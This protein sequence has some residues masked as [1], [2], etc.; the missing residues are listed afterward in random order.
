MP[1]QL[2]FIKHEHIIQALEIYDEKEMPKDNEWSQ[3]W[4]HY[5]GTLYQYKYVVAQASGFAGNPMKTT[6]FK[7]ND[8]SRNYIS[9]LGFHIL[10]REPKLSSGNPNFWIAGHH[11]GEPGNQQDMLHDFLKR[12]YWGTDHRPEL[13]EGKW[14]YNQLQHIRINDRIAIR[15]YDRKGGRVYILA[16]GTIAG[17]ENIKEGELSV[18]WDYHPPKYEGLKPTGAGTGNWWKTIFELKRPQDINLIFGH[19]FPNEFLEHRVCRLVWNDNGWIMPS[20]RDGKSNYAKSHEGAYG[21]GN[22]EWIFD[23]GKLING[24]HYALLAPIYLQEKTYSGKSF[25][26]SLYSIDGN[27]KNYYWVAE[28]K[29]TIVIDQQEAESVWKYYKEKGWLTKME[30]QI[31][32]KKG[33]HKS[34]RRWSGLE[35]FNIKFKLEDLVVYD[36][37]LIPPDSPLTKINRYSFA[38]YRPEFSLKATNEDR[39][40]VIPTEGEEKDLLI[41]DSRPYLRRP[42]MVQNRSVHQAICK[43]LVSH[44]KNQGLEIVRTEYPSGYNNTRIDIVVNHKQEITF[45]EIKTYPSLRA[46]IREALGQLMEYFYY[47]GQCNAKSMVIVSNLPI[48]GNDRRYLTYLRE[49]LKLPVYYQNFDLETSQL[50]EPY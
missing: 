28:L 44:F 45:Y 2:D 6:D 10:W 17:I 42:K 31:T 38:H 3:Y 4:I 41:P 46:C 20:G 47:P 18:K 16:L 35:L 27:T 48:D 15:S 25:R 13:N 43:G 23:T 37:E 26:I 36:Y 12:G 32:A 40:F 11:Y 30:E 24:Y 34:F 50:S 9:V 49:Q 5:K 39:G 29:K 22:D 14:V 1:H 21:Y 19:T 8:S 7:S 33:D